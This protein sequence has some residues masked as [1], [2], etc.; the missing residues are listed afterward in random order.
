MIIKYV[1][2]KKSLQQKNNNWVEICEGKYEIMRALKE[3]Q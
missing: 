1:K 2:H 3:Q